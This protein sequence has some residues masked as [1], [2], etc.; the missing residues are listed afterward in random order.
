VNAVH[1]NEMRALKSGH[2]GTLG[3]P[4]QKLVVANALISVC[5]LKS[6]AG[7]RLAHRAMTTECRLNEEDTWVEP[8]LESD[9]R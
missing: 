5:F 3:H 9:R 6:R 7:T 2:C 8:R 4:S 1:I